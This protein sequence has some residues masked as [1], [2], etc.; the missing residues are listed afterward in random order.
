LCVSGF[1]F[2]FVFNSFCKW[3]MVIFIMYGMLFWN[4]YTLCQAELI[5]ISPYTLPL[6]CEEA[7]SNI[8]WWRSRLGFGNYGHYIVQSPLISNSFIET[9]LK[10]YRSDSFWGYKWLWVYLQLGKPSPSS[11]LEQIPH[12]FYLSFQSANILSDYR[13]AS[14]GYQTVSHTAQGPSDQLT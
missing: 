10:W 14:F 6:F 3:K 8:S 4:M 9:Y 12:L 13:F 5:S 11:V 7:P 2:V 1:F